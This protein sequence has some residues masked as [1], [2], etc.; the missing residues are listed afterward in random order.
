M[1]DHTAA[2][3]AG[4]LGQMP[5]NHLLKRA[6]NFMISTMI[7]LHGAIALVGVRC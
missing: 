7:P 5:N 4:L 6:F 1:P 2:G 3:F